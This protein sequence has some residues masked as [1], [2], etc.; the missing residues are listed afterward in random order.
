MGS[1]GSARVLAARNGANKK[2]PARIC[3][4]TDGSK[5]YGTARLLP[6]Q[7]QLSNGD[8]IAWRTRRT[9]EA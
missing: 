8:R 7:K 9:F 4:D 6:H 5:E 3:A 2:I 1:V